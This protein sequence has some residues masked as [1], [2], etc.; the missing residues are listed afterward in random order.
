[1]IKYTTESTKKY[2]GLKGKKRRKP[3]P[4]HLKDFSHADIQNT[5]DYIGVTRE[6]KTAD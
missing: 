2:L 5:L 6:E 3:I 4:K 1:M